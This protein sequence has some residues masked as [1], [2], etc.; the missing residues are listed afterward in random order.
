MKNLTLIACMF[1]GY[2][3]AP[4]ASAHASEATYCQALSNKYETYAGTYGG[5]HNNVDQNS[6]VQ[7]AIDGCKAGDMSGIATLE[8]ALRNAKIDLP[9]RD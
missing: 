2:W 6:N 7:V 3:I 9:A 5:R 1:C 8:Q 4:A